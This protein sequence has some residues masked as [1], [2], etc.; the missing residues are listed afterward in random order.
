MSII[1]TN[2]IRFSGENVLPVCISLTGWARS[3]R[4]SETV[5]AD[6]LIFARARKRAHAHSHVTGGEM[7]Y[8]SNRALGAVL[9]IGLLRGPRRRVLLAYDRFET[10]NRIFFLTF[11]GYSVLCS[12]KAPEVAGVG[13]RMSGEGDRSWLTMEYTKSRKDKK[14]LH[15]SREL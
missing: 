14:I 3:A 6:S 8:A 13:V 4:D 1:R 2:L 11:S 5:R 9:H 12:A 7:H 15:S 10:R